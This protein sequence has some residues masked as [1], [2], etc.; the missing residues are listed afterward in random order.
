MSLLPSKALR[1]EVA[2][3]GKWFF[4][5]VLR[6]L[7]LSE[8]QAAQGKLIDRQAVEIDALREAVRTLQA[9][10]DRLEAREDVVLARAGEAA[11]KAAAAIVSDLAQRIGHL[12]A[13]NSRDNS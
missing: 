5:F 10:L 2:A 12:E 6:A 3:D 4:G 7:H 1:R 11:S 13:Q 8:T 9:R